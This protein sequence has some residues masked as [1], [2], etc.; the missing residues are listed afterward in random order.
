MLLAA[1]SVTKMMNCKGNDLF[2]RMARLCDDN[3]IPTP[4][5]SSQAEG[6]SA[7]DELQPAWQGPVRQSR[8]CSRAVAV[9]TGRRSMM[10]V[11]FS[12]NGVTASRTVS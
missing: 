8:F 12:P 11:I 4:G 9:D 1:L 5:T 10:M 3:V 2:N 6:L 7:D